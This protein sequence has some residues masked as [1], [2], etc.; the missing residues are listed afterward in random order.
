M[1]VVFDRIA[2]GCVINGLTV[3][4]YATCEA[5]AIEVGRAISCN[6]VSKEERRKRSLG[7][8]TLAQYAVQLA[9]SRIALQLESGIAQLRGMFGRPSYKAD[10]RAHGPIIRVT[11]CLITWYAF[12]PFV[13]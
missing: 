2:E 5:V 9:A 4:D 13:R 7:G 3:V 12:S 6:G 1:D 10:G 11:S 8:L